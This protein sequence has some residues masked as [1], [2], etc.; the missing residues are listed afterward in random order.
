M[1]KNP[2]VPTYDELINPTFKALKQLG[3]SGSNSEID[4]K[5]IEIEKISD[6][7]LSV[8]QKGYASKSVVVYRLAW[9]RTY[10]KKYGAINNTRRGIWSINNDFDNI[11]SINA[12]DVVKKIRAE[13]IVEHQNG[14]I[15]SIREEDVDELADISLK[16]KLHEKLMKLNP[17]DF[18]KLSGTLLREAGFSQLEITKKSGDGGIDGYGYLKLNDFISFK[19]AFQCKRYTSNVSS[20]EIRDFR[21]SMESDIKNGIFITTSDFTRDA[22]EE[23]VARGKQH[24]DLIN[25]DLLI[26][27]LIELKLG[28]KEEHVIDENFFSRI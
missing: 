17:Y 21:G 7:V 19:I 6:D 23:A 14:S 12:D 15:D 8:L 27:K 10:L 16:N 5:V 1:R 4:D 22:K 3:G 24:I 18:E 26:K 25:G 9:A 2:R 13:Q 11:D 28:V 20:K